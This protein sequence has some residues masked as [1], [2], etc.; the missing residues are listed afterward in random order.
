[1]RTLISRK[2]VRVNRSICIFYFLPIILLLACKTD[3]P[4]KPKNKILPEN[5]IS[6]AYIIQKAIEYSGKDKIQDNKITFKFRDKI[7]I[8]ESV[9]DQFKL[10]RIDS[11]KNVKDVLYKNEIERKINGKTVQLADTTST[12]IKSSINSVHY[13]VHLPYRLKDPAVQAQRL[14]DDTINEKGYYKLQ[15]EFNESGGG[16]DFQ[17]I[18]HYWFDQEDFSLDYLAYKFYTNDGG[19]RFRAKRVEK[20]LNDIIFQ[21][22][23]NFKPS[24]DTTQIDELSKAYQNN[25]MIKVSEII[26]IPLSVSLSKQNCN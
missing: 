8:S 17:D 16:E 9:C 13:F 10:I 22:Y 25:K 2:K 21:D 14:K 18:Y 11:S 5:K 4:Q 19:M 24:S 7:Y 20:R 3:H 15:V 1:M 26:T 23:N 6:P 12:N